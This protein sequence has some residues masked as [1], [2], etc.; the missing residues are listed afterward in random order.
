MYHQPAGGAAETISGG[1]SVI[2]TVRVIHGVPNRFTPL[3]SG[4]ISSSP[5]SVSQPLLLGLSTRPT[6]PYGIYQ[7]PRGEGYRNRISS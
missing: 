5:R 1:P 3:E 4:S 6:V 7:R 2:D